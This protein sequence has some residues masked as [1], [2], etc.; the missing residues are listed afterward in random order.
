[1]MEMKTSYSSPGIE[2]IQFVNVQSRE[3]HWFICNVFLH[4]R[5]IPVLFIILFLEAI[6]RY[7][8]GEEELY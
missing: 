3:V 7:I 2:S 5:C 4:A 8:E 1:M 6:S